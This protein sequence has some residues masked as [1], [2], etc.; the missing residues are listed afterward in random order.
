MKHTRKDWILWGA[1]ACAL[2]GTAHAEYTLGMATGGH[3]LV[4]GSVVGALDLYVVRALQVR[5]DVLVAVLVMVAANVASRLVHAGV[6]PV[7]WPLYSAVGA[8]APF[9]LWRIQYLKRAHPEHAPGTPEHTDTVS[10]SEPGT[11]WSTC[12]HLECMG[13][14]TCTVSVS[15][16]DWGRVTELAS[17]YPKHTVSEPDTAEDTDWDRDYLPAGWTKESVLEPST[18]AEHTVSE[19]GTPPVLDLPPGFKGVSEPDTGVS[20]LSTPPD[21]LEARDVPHWGT[22]VAYL[23]TCSEDASTPG[24]RDFMRFGSFGQDRARR[25]MSAAGV[26]E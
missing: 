23:D 15:G 22:L 25:L 12:E 24:L 2:V 17:A 18:P 5:K 11:P 16:T 1:L 9:L 4:A 21:T 19:P 8:L 6:L 10:V 13:Y 14:D 26:P 20:V 7:G 3:W